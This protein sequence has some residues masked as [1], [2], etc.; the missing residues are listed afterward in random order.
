M[1]QKKTLLPVLFTSIY[2][3]ADHTALARVKTSTPP[4]PAFSNSRAHSL[5]VDPVVITSSIKRIL[6]PRTLLGSITAKEPFTFAS[7]SPGLK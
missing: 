3:I 1:I 6:F 2:S 5:T 4:A 7:L